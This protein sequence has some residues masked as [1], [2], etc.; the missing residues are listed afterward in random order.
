MA[1]HECKVQNTSTFNKTVELTI[2]ACG[3]TWEGLCK[4]E[5]EITVSMFT[6]TD[7]LIKITPAFISPIE[8]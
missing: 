7:K 6:Q 5:R 1:K 2:D 4:K 8:H 3:Y